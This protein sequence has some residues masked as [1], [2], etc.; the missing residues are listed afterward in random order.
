MNNVKTL[1]LFSLLTGLLVAIGWIIGG[2]GGMIAFLV[3]AGIMNFAA[4]WFSDKLVLRMSGAREVTAD[5]EPRLH[6]L[7]EDVVGLT[8]L[9]KPK[10]YIV[11]SDTP[12][13]FATGRNPKNAAVAVTTGIARILDYQ[14]L[15]A[16]I[17]H[18]LGHIRNRDTLIQTVV[19]TVAG[20]I[21]MIAWMLQWTL[22]FGGGRRGGRDNPLA[23]I[24][25][26]A[27]VIL[28]PLAAT[29]I[30]LA[31][32]RA[33]EFEADATGARMIHDP[34]AL[35]NALLKLHQGVQM[36]PLPDNGATEA[37]A[38]LYIVN[39][40]KSEGLVGLFSTHPSVEERVRRL[41]A[42]AGLS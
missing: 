16:V 3:L 34:E 9:P 38:H 10:V 26:L 27:A 22:L 1:F 20:A 15:K 18:E 4:F 36:H 14:E 31:I 13:A 37:T 33:R 23:I 28:A 8:G 29:V 30:R 24:G 25:L 39:P 40:L 19:A 2:F 7:V 5:E 21:T 32:S 17:A 42:M 35:A 41:R 6:A 11:Q 12:N